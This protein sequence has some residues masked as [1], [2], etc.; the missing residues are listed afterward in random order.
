MRERLNYRGRK[1]IHIKKGSGFCQA[2][3]Y[4]DTL[5]GQRIIIATGSMGFGIVWEKPISE[6]EKPMC[7]KCNFLKN[8][9]DRQILRYLIG[10]KK[11]PTWHI[12]E[13]EVSKD[14]GR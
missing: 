9:T 10:E 2:G 5:C 12:T 3:H 6:M 14:V 11:Y 4:K 1:I 8:K 13:T 7:R